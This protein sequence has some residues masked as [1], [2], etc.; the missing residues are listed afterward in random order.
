MASPLLLLLLMLMILCMS[1][2]SCQ[3]VLLPLTHSLSKAQFN[4]TH[5]L[6]KSTSTRSAARFRHHRQLSLPLSPGSD[7]TLSF[8]LGPQAQAQPITLYMDTGSDLVWFPCAPFKCILCEG[9]PSLSLSSPTNIS[10]SIAVSCKSSACSAAHNSIPSS[11]LCAMARCPLESIETSDCASFSCPPFY[12]AYGDGSLIAR[13]YRDTLSLSSL[14]L[15]NF[16]FGCAHT[17][18]AEPIGVAGFGRGLLSFPA[19]LAT[20]APQLGNRFSYCLVSHSFDSERVRRPSPLILGRY[21]DK[22]KKDGDGGEMV[23]FAYT[24][25]LENPKHPYFYCVGLDGISVGKRT[26]PAPEMLR[27]VNRRG[28][29]GVVVDSGTTFTM[30]PAGFYDSVV[31]EFDGRVGRENERA[32]RVEEKTGLAPCYYLNA[33]V[34]VPAVTLRFAGGNS[35]VVLPRKNFFYEFLDGGDGTRRK[36][37]VGCLMLMNGGD[38]AELSG[39]PGATL[40]NYQQQ[41]FE[42]V[43]DLEEKRVGFARRQCASLWDK[44]NRDKN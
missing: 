44:L 15:K 25:M 11:D 43:Y 31:A 37:R 28:D 14:F 9:K 22:E 1:H 19:Q 24:P 12:Y 20:Q 32:R 6:L 41:G 4:S 5:H 10:Q 2:P 21:D 16:T 34:K 39:G 8:N 7:Y 29:G 40:G 18:L 23:E 27:R 42:V 36:R 35:S 33:M 38:E 26:I 3:M 17:T 13:L 30:L